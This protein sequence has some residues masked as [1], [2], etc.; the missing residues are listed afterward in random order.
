MLSSVSCLFQEWSESE[1]F[2]HSLFI[3][4]D[5]KIL[6]RLASTGDD[7]IKSRKPS[8][9]CFSLSSVYDTETV[10][11]PPPPPRRPCARCAPEGY[12]FPWLTI[13]ITLRALYPVDYGLL[14]AV[15][16]CL[17]MR[18]DTQPTLS[19]PNR[20]KSVGYTQSCSVVGKLSVVVF[21]SLHM[22]TLRK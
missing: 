14:L 12:R 5:R 4:I 17:T 8:L 15:I 18:R 20:L 16:L 2:N 11:D 19:Q 21:V 13:R 3:S 9:L 22:T 1:P 6:E 10:T 7:R